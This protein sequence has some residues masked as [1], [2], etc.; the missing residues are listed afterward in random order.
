[1]SDEI[2]RQ[3]YSIEEAAKVLGVGRGLAYQLAR[4]GQLPVLRLGRRLLVS[5]AVLESLLEVASN[6]IEEAR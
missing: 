4:S 2:E 1:M 3:T 6:G 5:K